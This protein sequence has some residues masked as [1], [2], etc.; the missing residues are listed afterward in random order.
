MEI[1]ILSDT[2]DV[3][4]AIDPLKPGGIYY[5]KKLNRSEML[6]IVGAGNKVVSLFHE[7]HGRYPKLS[8][9]IG[10]TYLSWFSE[11]WYQAQHPASKRTQTVGGYTLVED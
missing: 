2:G 10:Q 11:A 3:L 6:S 7:K 5:G 1:Q 9:A 8:E 4:V